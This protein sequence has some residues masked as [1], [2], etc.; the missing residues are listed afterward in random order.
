MKA[1]LVSFLV[2]IGSGLTVVKLAAQSIPAAPCRQVDLGI[3]T[4]KR[5][6][7]K[8]FIDECDKEKYF[9]YDKGIIHLYVYT[10]AKGLTNWILAPHIDD[11]YK[12]NPTA[13]FAVFD[14][15]IILVYAADA[16]ARVEMNPEPEPV[17]RCLQDIIGDRV[18][19]RPTIRRR[20]VPPYKMPGMDRVF[21]EGKRRDVTGGGG[22]IHV[23][24]YKN[25]T[26]K[27]KYMA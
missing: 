27:I 26:Y 23:L 17:N 25:G 14:D 6:I 21:T 4:T 20:W 9:V 16:N 22:S 3:D 18:Y 5:R 2:L 12:N 24:F 19:L 1:L 13:S 11:W 8:N 7:L 15:Y 10:D